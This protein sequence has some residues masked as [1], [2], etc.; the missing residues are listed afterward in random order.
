MS[1]IHDPAGAG[2]RPGQ[3][4][5]ALPSAGGFSRVFPH[6]GR[7]P[8]PRGLSPEMAERTPRRGAPIAGAAAFLDLFQR[9]EI[10]SARPA[11][12]HPRRSNGD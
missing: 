5:L 3:L 10:R 6:T 4:Y 12:R 9:D 2:R 7:D 11:G 8:A 1:S